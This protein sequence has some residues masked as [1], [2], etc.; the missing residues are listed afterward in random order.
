MIVTFLTGQRPHLLRRTLG[1]LRRNQPGILENN[2]CLVLHN[3][4]DARTGRVLNLYRD[5][6]DQVVTTPELEGIGPASSLLFQHA[7]EHDDDY[8]LHLEDDWEAGHGDWLPLATQLLDDVFQV[9][10]RHT[11]QKVLTRHMVTRAPLR[12]EDHD[13]YR[14]TADAHYTSNPALI[15]LADIGK[16]YPAVGERDAQRQF[17]DAGCRTV[18]QIVPGIWKHIGGGAESLRKRV[19]GS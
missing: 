11:S 7:A 18:A 3:G 19:E 13:E 1:S 12:W 5:Y 17:W 16:G 4:G 10:L 8:L 14:I 9:R 15:R 6:I 2:H